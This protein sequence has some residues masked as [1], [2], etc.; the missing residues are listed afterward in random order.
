MTDN[1]NE[2][3]RGD[4]GYADKAKLKTIKLTWKLDLKSYVGGLNM[5]MVNT[6]LTV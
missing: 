2:R 6:E 4:G 1:L 3:E 5:S